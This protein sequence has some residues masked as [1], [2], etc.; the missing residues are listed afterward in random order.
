M[1]SEQ[2]FRLISRLEIIEKEKEKNEEE[3]IK[4][5]IKVSDLETELKELKKNFETLEYNLDALLLNLL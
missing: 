4:L 2:N 3:K 5:T 1:D